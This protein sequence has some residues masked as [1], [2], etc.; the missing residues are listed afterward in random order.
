[1]RLGAAG[2]GHGLHASQQR[3][4]GLEFSQYRS[5]EPGDDL[6]Q[7][8][9]KL[10]ARSDRYFVREAERES[11][12]SLWI[13]LD[14][15]ASMTQVDQARPHTTRLD[16]AKEIA[17]CAI[18]LALQGSDRFGLVAVNDAQV[19]P[20]ASGLGARHRDRCLLAL[21]AMRS[22]GRWPDAT[23]LSPAWNMLTPRSLVLLLSDC[24][25]DAVVEM[26]EKLAA[27]GRDVCIVQVLMA[28]ERD[29]PYRGGHLFVDTENAATLLGDADALRSEYLQR[30]ADARA[31]LQARCTRVGIRLATHFADTPI[32][33]PLQALF[34]AQART[35]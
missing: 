27:T 35:A 17:A 4:S 10:F 21:D 31:E 23:R 7:V 6:R 13:V 34:S 26:A 30:F 3:G 15:T 9:W 33:A 5:Y 20:T 1:M 29:F 22:A 14:A 24:F 8:D 28:D 25:D 18:Q 32:D 11:P 2:H 19:Q 16:I 12:L